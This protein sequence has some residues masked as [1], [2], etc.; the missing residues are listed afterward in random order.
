M[1]YLICK[2]NKNTSTLSTNLPN[3]QTDPQSKYQ[4]QP[5]KGQAPVEKPQAVTTNH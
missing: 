5:S 2:K 4:W 1:N 3:D